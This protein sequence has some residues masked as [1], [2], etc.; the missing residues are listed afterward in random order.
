MNI[1]SLLSTSKICHDMTEK[2]LTLIKKVLEYFTDFME[3]APS[4]VGQAESLEYYVDTASEL[5]NEGTINVL[6]F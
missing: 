3:E 2:L 1:L 6:K 4:G 5:E